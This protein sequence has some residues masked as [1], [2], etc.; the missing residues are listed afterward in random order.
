[1]G[2]LSVV[3]PVYN[4]ESYLDECL[5]SLINQTVNDFSI[6]CVNDG[7]TDSSREVLSKWELRD[8]R[9]RVIDKDNGGLSSARNA[10]IDVVE[11]EYVCFLDSDDRFHRDACERITELMDSS[12]ADVLT[13]GATCLPPE[14]GYPWLLDVLSPRDVIYDDFSMDILLKEK[15]RPF[16]WR[17]ACRSDFI[18]S[19]S[20]RFD[21][22]VKF[23]EDQVFHFAVYPRSSKTAFSSEK[24][25]DYRV[26]REGSLMFRMN[27]SPEIKLLEHVN[28][29]SAILKDWSRDGLIGR[30]ANGL[31]E[32]IVEFVLFDA[33]KLPTKD[34]RKV[35]FELRKLLKQ[36][37]SLTT[38]K[39]LD[40]ASEVRR[41]LLCACYRLQSITPLRM[42]I[43][44][45][46]CE[47]RYGK[48]AAA[49][50][51]GK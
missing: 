3:V 45:S 51:F 16:A 32:W 41:P 18:R 22:S 13:F 23:G 37:F 33:M 44:R 46:Y 29:A 12:G 6:I 39:S 15:S 9:I 50:E 49:R 14:A 5:D 28:I 1:M 11:T 8:S 7:S 43:A 19:H 27:M 31:L 25:Y 42:R 10:G 21:E 34:Y 48:E 17:T 2:K 38:I 35:A 24:L 26:A 40:L 20:I 30:Y 4:V 36:F 47:W